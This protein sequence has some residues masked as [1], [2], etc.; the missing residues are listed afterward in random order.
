M[1]EMVVVVVETVGGEGG[2]EVGREQHLL[3]VHHTCTSGLGFVGGV[4]PSTIFWEKPWSKVSALLPP[5][6][7][8]H[9]YRA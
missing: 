3:V 9:F 2:G 4:V 1:V 5:G 7:C 8:F 6:T